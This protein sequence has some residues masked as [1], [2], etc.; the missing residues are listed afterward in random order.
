M[1]G[2]GFLHVRPVSSNHALDVLKESGAALYAVVLTQP[3]NNV[4]VNTEE[5]RNRAI[6]LADGSDSTGGRLIHVISSMHAAIT[7][8]IPGNGS[9]PSRNAWTAASFAALSTTGIVP[10]ASRAA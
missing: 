3:G 9:R 10:P 2:D 6:V 5:G 1:F 8:A 7:R 4:A